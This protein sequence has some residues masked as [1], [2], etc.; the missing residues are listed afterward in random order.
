MLR[1]LLTLALAVLL[2]GGACAK[3]VVI[4]WHGQSFFEVKSS[5]GTLIVLDPHN[6]EA[7]GRHE[8]NADAVLMSHYHIDHNAPE[9]IAN[10]DKAKRFYG[11]KKT[12]ENSAP[13][14]NE[15]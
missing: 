7:Y 1:S 15:E 3:N 9:P 13:G 6:I 10:W 2:A 8:I 4:K 14:K 12:K 5:K 11:L